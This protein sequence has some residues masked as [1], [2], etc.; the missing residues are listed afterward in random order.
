MKTFCKFRMQ[1]QENSRVGSQ[2]NMLEDGNV[3]SDVLIGVLC[4][5]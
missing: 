5:R 2:D 1:K 3:V 4:V